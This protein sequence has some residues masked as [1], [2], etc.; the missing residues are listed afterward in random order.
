MRVSRRRSGWTLVLALA[1]VPL[2]AAVSANAANAGNA[3]NAGNAA[4]PAPP[5]AK[6][7]E[8]FFVVSSLDAAHGRMVLKRPTEVTLVMHADGRTA[9]RNERGQPLTLHDLRTGDTVYIT[10]R[11]DSA[12]PTA[13]LVRQ[14]PMT[15]PELERRYLQ[16][17]LVPARP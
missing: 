7:V 6:S 4:R 3:V 16:P 11:P 17:S 1:L 2:A 5:A 15:V 14:G 13:L 12:E 9:Y 10:Y 8:D